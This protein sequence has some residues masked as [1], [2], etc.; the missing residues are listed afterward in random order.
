MITI[1]ANIQAYR[2]IKHMTQAELAEQLHVSRQTI[3]KWE[4][5]KSTPSIEY[6]VQLSQKLNVTLDQLVIK[7]G[8]KFEK[9]VGTIKTNAYLFYTKKNK[10]R[11]PLLKC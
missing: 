4:L 10:F 5:D 6:L 9:I 11:N 3:S 1:E 8:S 2:K 7:T